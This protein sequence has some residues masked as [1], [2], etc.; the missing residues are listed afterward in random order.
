LG[1]DRLKISVVVPFKA[2]LAPPY[3]LAIV[4]GSFV[5]GGEPPDDPPPHAQLQKK[6]IVTSMSTTN[7]DVSWKVRVMG[8]ITAAAGAKPFRRP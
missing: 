4:G 2:T 5:G 1:F 8:L 7:R 3:A 6:L